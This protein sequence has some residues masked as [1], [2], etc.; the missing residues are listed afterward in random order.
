MNKT[1]VGDCAEVGSSDSSFEQKYPSN[2]S[3]DVRRTYQDLH[4]KIIDNS[5]KYANA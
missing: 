1:Q 3:F 4:G 5:K 2:E